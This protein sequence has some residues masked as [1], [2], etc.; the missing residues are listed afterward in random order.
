MCFPDAVKNINIKVFN[1]LS[2]T[3]EARYIAEHE[4]CACKCRLH[5][6]VFNDRQRWT[7]DKCRC[8]CREWVDKG[9]SDN[10]FVSNPSVCVNVN[11]INHVKL[12]NT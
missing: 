12:V 4:N 7:S 2:K 6:S 8:E 5:E 1:L 11:V 10:V 9:R 3:N